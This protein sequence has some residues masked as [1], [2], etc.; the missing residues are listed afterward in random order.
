MAK[1]GLREI[2]GAVAISGLIGHLPAKYEPKPQLEQTGCYAQRTDPSSVIDDFQ[3]KCGILR[4]YCL[5]LQITVNG[6]QVK[7][8]VDYQSRDN[9]CERLREREEIRPKITNYEL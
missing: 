5:P 2:G 6:E 7:V 1:L 9:I 4:T 8:G 3:R